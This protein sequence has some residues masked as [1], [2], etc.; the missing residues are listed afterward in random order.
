VMNPDHVII[1]GIKFSVKSGVV[2]RSGFSWQIVS[3]FLLGV[4]LL[5]R[6]AVVLFSAQFPH[7]E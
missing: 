6:D 3:K 4:G 5:Y 7:T 1:I 2:L